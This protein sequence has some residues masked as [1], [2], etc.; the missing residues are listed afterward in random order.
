MKFSKTQL[1]S[2]IF[3]L[4]LIGI[5][6]VVMVIY[7]ASDS[8]SNQQEPVPADPTTFQNTKPLNIKNAPTVAPDTGGGTDINSP[9]VK[10]SISEIETLNNAL[11]FERS[12]TTSQGIEV[13]ILIPR[14]SLQTNSWTLKTQI[15]GINYNTSPEQ[16]DYEAMR[17]SFIEAA[18]VVFSWVKQNNADPG[19]IIYVWGDK[20]FIQDQAE[21]WLAPNN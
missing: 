3:I 8:P 19:K 15:F 9:I 17:R 12:F 11:P 6:S 13:T 10:N 16:E 2:L 18:N 7:L 14:Q 20:K 5:M 4:T 1:I 21:N